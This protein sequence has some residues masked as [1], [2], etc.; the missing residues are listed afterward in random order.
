MLFMGIDISKPIAIKIS[1]V[2]LIGFID[3]LLG[4]LSKL[5]RN[6][7]QRTIFDIHLSSMYF[8]VP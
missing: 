2:A 7:L 5:I 8:L 1:A 6:H 3:L 4:M